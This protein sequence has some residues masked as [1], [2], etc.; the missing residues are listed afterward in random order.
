MNPYFPI[1]TEKAECQ[2]CY[3]CVRSCSSKAIKVE[4]GSASVLQEMCVMCGRCVQV[5][6]AGAKKVRNDIGRVKRLLTIKE[7][8][9]VSLAPSYM[10]EFNASPAQMINALKKLG[11]WGVS[12]TALGA[13][14][15]SAHVARQLREK[16][17]QLLISSACPTVVQYIKKYYPQ[18]SD[19][20]TTL[21]SPL[22][23]HATMLKSIYGPDIS[24]V[25]VGPCIAK[26]YEADT[27]SDLVDIAITFKNLQSWF[28]EEAIIPAK[29]V[30]GKDDVFIPEAAHE[31]GL[32]PVDGGML[33]GIKANCSVHDAH[34]MS[35]SGLDIIKKALANLEQT[36]KN[37]FIEML[38]CEGGCINGPQ[39]S[40]QGATISKRFRVV[41]HVSYPDQDIPRQPGYDITNEQR[42]TCLETTEYDEF[43]VR[44]A[45]LMAGKISAEDELNCGGCGYDTCREFAIAMLDGKAEP[46]MCVSFMRKR[47]HKTA[48]ALLSSIPSGVVIVDR[49]LR[50][51]ECNQNFAK[52]MGGDSELIYDARPGMEG[53]NLQ[54]LVPFASFFRQVL[55][56]SVEKRNKNIR[57]QN[58]IL[59]VTLFTIEPGRTAGGIIQ[60]ITAPA[61][62]KEQIIERARK[63]IENHLS[64]VQQ[65]AFLLG[66]NASEN[67]VILESI[68]ESFSPES[69][70][71]GADDE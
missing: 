28:Q 34:F 32:Y 51:I 10:S 61:M 2:D 57:Y 1:Y 31:G 35:F 66:E 19:N 68:I 43:L 53:A 64:T 49:D 5:C 30:P 4:N 50:I 67:E 41:D 22:L 23:A 7:R 60:D 71:K 39:A 40:V 6:P 21:H 69:I 37:L 44:E 59:N 70:Q 38:A 13:Q 16:T 11:F 36:D 56:G 20:I 42:V 26:K 33:A 58:R 18:Y 14:E 29:L 65:I 55:E 27:F 45:L 47:A 24:V 8:V 48:N 9:V 12:E 25:F 3:K 46:D 52:L 54:K 15:V 17:N 63:V 62:Q